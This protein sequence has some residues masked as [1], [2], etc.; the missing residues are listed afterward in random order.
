MRAWTLLSPE[1][2]TAE[3][4]KIAQN[5]LEWPLNEVVSVLAGMTLSCLAGAAR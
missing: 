3:C 4:T 1:P 2:E 5:A